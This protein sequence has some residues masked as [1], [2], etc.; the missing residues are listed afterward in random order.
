MLSKIKESILLGLVFPLAD[1]VMGTCAMK[2]YRQIKRMNSW[3]SQE[4][5][6]WQ[7][8]Q[9]QKLI[10][11]VYNHTRYYRE[12][13][14]GLGLK[15]QDIKTLDD[16]QKLPVL[17]R[18]IIKKRFEDL[19][20]DN[21][22][23]Y[24]HRNCATGGSTGEPIKYLCGESTWGFVTAMKIFSWQQ[25]GYHYG[26]RFVSLGCSS[27]FP[28]NK[29]SLVSEIYF[30]L[31]NTIP[32]NGMNMDDETCARYMEI[33]RKKNVR[34]IYGYATA[35]YLLAKYCRDNHVSW[36]FRAVFPSSEKLTP[37]YRQIIS[38]T[39]DAP[40]FDCYGSR[41]GG[42][43]AYE[44]EPGIYHVGYATWFEASDKEPS[45]LY[46]TNLIDFSFPTIRYANCD[47]VLMWN[48]SVKSRYNGQLL[49]EVIGRTSDI[50]SFENGHRLTT[51]G[52]GIMFRGF[53]VESFRIKKNGPM[54]ILV[55]IKKK[56]TFSDEEHD[57]L[58]ATMK[59]HVGEGVDVIIESVDKFEPLPNGKRSFFINA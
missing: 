47:E 17:T 28:V 20:P 54:S 56:D 35:I 25:C 13:M 6:D 11:H 48:H 26:D 4:I 46:S 58:Y 51:T 8:D 3:T 24:P 27:L 19:I 5:R 34:F 45:T 49:K 1:K 39:W 23:L 57:L 59:K 41:D 52:F 53:N 22:D 50:I 43:T 38:E 37:L 29:K 36:Q 12:V 40:V 21:I 32:L 14:D 44:L 31:R 15:P 7:T 9:I 55:Q 33:I 2:W 18:D 30:R 42:N 10:A 16:F